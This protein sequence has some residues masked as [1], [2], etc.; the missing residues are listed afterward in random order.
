MLPA[1]EWIVTGG[2]NRLELR[3]RRVAAT[4]PAHWGFWG[5][6]PGFHLPPPSLANELVNSI[7]PP[8]PGKTASRT[9]ISFPPL[10]AGQTT[11]PTGASP[12]T[13]NPP[14]PPPDPDRSLTGATTCPNWFLLVSFCRRRREVDYFWVT[15]YLPTPS[16]QILVSFPSRWFRCRS[17]EA[18]TPH[19][20]EAPPAPLPKTG[21]GSSSTAF[22]RRRRDS[23]VPL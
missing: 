17:G 11:V 19:P 4:L 10:E 21:A 14:N 12:A 3:L 2:G 6:P 9:E 20:G 13:I 8:P 1:A 16:G 5:A 15:F 22:L 18:T 23:S 7:N